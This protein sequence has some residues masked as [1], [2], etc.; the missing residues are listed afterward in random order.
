MIISLYDFES[1]LFRQLG[2]LSLNLKYIF[3][4]SNVH[5][6][7]AQKFNKFDR[8]VIRNA[9]RQTLNSVVWS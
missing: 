4:I 7:E 6:V 2:L 1:T 3:Q 8:D 9:W 5:S